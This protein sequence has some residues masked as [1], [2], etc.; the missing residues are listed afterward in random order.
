[1]FPPFGTVCPHFYYCYF[2]I[3]PPPARLRWPWCWPSPAP[4]S[5]QRWIDRESTETTGGRQLA[6]LLQAGR[7]EVEETSGGLDLVGPINVYWV[8]RQRARPLSVSLPRA[9]AC[10]LTSRPYL[11]WSC[12]SHLTAQPPHYPRVQKLKQWRNRGTHPGTQHLAQPGTSPSF[13]VAF[14]LAV[15]LEDSVVQGAV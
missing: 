9:W 12:P 11:P 2:V 14:P 10:L 1:M 6:L 4:G 5:R 13:C 7:N 15:W 8:A 3:V